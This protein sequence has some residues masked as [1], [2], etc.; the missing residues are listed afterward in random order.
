[1]PHLT[2]DTD[3]EGSAEPPTVGHPEGT[4]ERMATMSIVRIN[5]LEV[6]PEMAGE[7]ERRFQARAGEIDNT[8]GFE[9]FALLRPTDGT[10][11]YLVYTRWESEEAFDAWVQSEAFQKGHAHSERSGP[12]AS[13]SQLWSFDVVTES[14]AQ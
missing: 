14:R 11:R 7:L 1:M 8:P 13:H 2:T 5:A 3:A 4:S 9:E 6:P 10:D 12:A